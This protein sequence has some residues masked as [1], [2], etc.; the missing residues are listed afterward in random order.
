MTLVNV[1][2][3]T[4]VNN[5]SLC[6][7]MRGFLFLKTSPSLE[8]CFHPYEQSYTKF[9]V[10]FKY[11]TIHFCHLITPLLTLFVFNYT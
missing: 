10:I 2:K 5:K 4:L 11:K 1:K 9:S 6:E 7:S 8:N 3:S